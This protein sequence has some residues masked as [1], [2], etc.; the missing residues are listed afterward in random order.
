[1]GPN[2]YNDEFMRDEVR[3]ITKT[4]FAYRNGNGLGAEDVLSVMLLGATFSNTIRCHTI[5][6][7]RHNQ[8]HAV[9]CCIAPNAFLQW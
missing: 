8:W 9:A 2:E 1:M 4:S 3:Q 5:K 7:H 6:V